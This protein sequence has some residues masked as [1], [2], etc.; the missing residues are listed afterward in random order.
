MSGPQRA[1]ARGSRCGASGL[2]GGTP[3]PAR[4]LGFT[5]GVEEDVDVADLA[6]EVAVCARENGGCRVEDDDTAGLARGISS[7]SI[8]TSISSASPFPCAAAGCSTATGGKTA[9]SMAR[10]T[11]SLPSASQ[12]SLSSF[13]RTPPLSL[14]LTLPLT[15]SLSLATENAGAG[16]A[17]AAAAGRVDVDVHAHSAPAPPSACSIFASCEI[18]LRCAGICGIGSL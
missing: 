10:I 15:R 2:G 6:V 12:S 13:S 7:P 11:Q 17:D 5:A 14:P 4:R 18:R 8:S 3:G 9:C 16:G 1:R